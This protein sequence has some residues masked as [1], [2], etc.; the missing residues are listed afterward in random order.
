MVHQNSLADRTRQSVRTA[1]FALLVCGV[2]LVAGCQNRKKS[3]ASDSPK[4]AAAL[5]KLGERIQ[6]TNDGLPKDGLAADGSRLYFIQ[7]P[8]KGPPKLQAYPIAGA[9]S[10]VIDAA[11]PKP[12]ILDVSPDSELLVSSG[13]VGSGDLPLWVVPASGGVPHRLGQ[14]RGAAAAWMPDGKILF[15]KGRDLY[16]TEHDGS[17]PVKVASTP[18]P[19]SL[20]RVS[21]DGTRMRFTMGDLP[22]STIWEAQVDGTG[23]KPLVPFPGGPAQAC[24]GRW[25]PDGKYFVYES[26][27]DLWMIVGTGPVSN[28]V[29]PPVQLTT[30]ALAYHDPVPARDGRKLFAFAGARPAADGAR[31]SEEVYAFDWQ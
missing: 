11:I 13:N 7:R 20:L 18:G 6:I 16:R 22:R 2:I 5:P 4:P 9:A 17:K 19:I 12:S 21:P 28:R 29:N 3:P 8:V 27:G 15:S 24:C 26:A 14:I 25:T 30:G 10:T 1:A 31:S 23:M